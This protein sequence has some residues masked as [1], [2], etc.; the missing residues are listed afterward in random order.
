MNKLF[1]LFQKSVTFLTAKIT[2]PLT[3]HKGAPLIFLLVG[4]LNKNQLA[5]L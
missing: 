5:L 1:S 3:L 2:R 4:I